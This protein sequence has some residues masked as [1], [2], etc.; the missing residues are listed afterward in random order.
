LTSPEE[1]KLSKIVAKILLLDEPDVSDDL[2]RKNV[3]AWDSLAHLMLISEV[4]SAF[5]VTLDDDDI[6]AINT[7]GD[8]RRTLKKL[9]VNI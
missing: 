4:E 7:V 5:G 6:I 3:E 2:S 9:G 8:I 1:E